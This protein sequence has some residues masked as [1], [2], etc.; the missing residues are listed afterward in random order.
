[1]ATVYASGT[2]Q[3]TAQ[4]TLDQHATVSATGLC[5]ICMVPGPC[6]R[7]ESAAA[8]FTRSGRLPRRTPGLSR[9]EL[10]GARQIRVHRAANPTLIVRPF[11]TET[12]CEPQR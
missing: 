2:A 7:W 6:E 3:A 11:S 12:R 9:P 4:W 5:R 8:V 10:I 1:M